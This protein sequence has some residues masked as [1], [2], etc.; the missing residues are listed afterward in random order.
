MQIVGGPCASYRR[1]EKPKVLSLE[2]LRVSP[3]RPVEDNWLAR[4]L[5][6]AWL[7]SRHDLHDLRIFAR[8]WGPVNP[9]TGHGARSFL[10]AVRTVSRRQ[11]ASGRC[12]YCLMVL[13]TSR[14]TGWTITVEMAPSEENGSLFGP[15]WLR[16]QEC[17]RGIIMMKDRTAS[18][19]RG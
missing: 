2:A 18:I 1:A 7:E 6:G 14:P 11:T 3:T 12:S 19:D 13:V 8:P 10:V 16:L 17:H 5:S 9:R 15:N 4:C